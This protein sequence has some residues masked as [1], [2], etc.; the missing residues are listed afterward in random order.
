M[1]RQ[2]RAA[3]EFVHAVGREPRRRIALGRAYWCDEVVGSVRQRRIVWEGTS[4][5]ACNAHLGGRLE[6]I[7]GPDEGCEEQLRCSS[8][9]CDYGLTIVRQTAPDDAAALAQWCTVP[10]RE[11][12]E[13]EPSRFAKIMLMLVS[14]YEGQ[15]ATERRFPKRIL[16]WAQRRTESKA[17][18]SRGCVPAASVA[19]AVPDRRSTVRQQER[20]ERQDRRGQ[21]D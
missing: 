17:V 13:L 14:E 21:P 10:L 16:R 3:K 6:H 5:P 2:I 18:P 8:P 4:C 15:G 19:P 12:P 20:D 7:V 9:C 1:S 11:R